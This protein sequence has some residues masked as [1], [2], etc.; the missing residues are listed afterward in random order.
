MGHT[1]CKPAQKTAPAE[2]KTDQVGRNRLEYYEAARVQ[3][4]EYQILKPCAKTSDGAN[5][6]RR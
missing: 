5:S 6:P 2:Q 1:W 4:A 3:E